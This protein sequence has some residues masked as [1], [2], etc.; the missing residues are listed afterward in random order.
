MTKRTIAKSLAGLSS[1][2]FVVGLYVPL[3]VV[4]DPGPSSMAYGIVLVSFPA[5]GVGVLSG[6]VAGYLAGRGEGRVEGRAA[7]LARFSWWIG[8][9]NLVALVICLTWQPPGVS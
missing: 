2:G 8:G 9:L 7:R 3:M 1:L 5:W 4:L 6:G